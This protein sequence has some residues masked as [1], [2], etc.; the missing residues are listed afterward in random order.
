MNDLPPPVT[1]S[2]EARKRWIRMFDVLTP[3]HQAQLLR[4]AELLVH[5][6]PKPERDNAPERPPLQMIRGGKPQGRRKAART[7]GGPGPGPGPDAA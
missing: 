2:T 4:C 5:Y 7:H 3:E 1:N 6:E